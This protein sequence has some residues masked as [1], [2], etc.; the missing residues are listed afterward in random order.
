MKASAAGLSQRS[1]CCLTSPRL[2]GEVGTKRRMRGGSAFGRSEHGSGPSP[3]PSAASRGSETGTTRAQLWTSHFR[4]TRCSMNWRGTLARQQRRRAGGAARRRQD[5]AGAAGAARR[6]MAGGQENHC[7]GA[8]PDRGPR[9]RRAHGQVVGRTVVKPSATASGSV[10]RCRARRGS[11]LSPR[12]FSRA[13][14]P[15]SGVDR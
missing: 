8:A 10:R 12:A 5:D 13:D 14:T 2:R 4:S 7:A 6:A 11:R 1:D 9:Q 3:Q 15:L